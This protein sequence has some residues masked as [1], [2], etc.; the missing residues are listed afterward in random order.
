[1]VFG[2]DP[3][4]DPL[5]RHRYSIIDRVDAIHLGRPRDVVCRD[6]PREAAGRTHTLR[7]GKKRLPALELPLGLTHLLFRVFATGDLG[8]DAYLPKRP[9][10]VRV[11]RNRLRAA[12]GSRGFQSLPQAAQGDM[13]LDTPRDLF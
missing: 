9:L 1:M 11:R 10:Q 12:V 7:F 5:P 13:G 6:T 2:M 3:T 4:A 8:Q